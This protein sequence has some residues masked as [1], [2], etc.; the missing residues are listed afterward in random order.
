M[1]VR[2]STL[3]TPRR[4]RRGHSRGLGSSLVTR[5]RGWRAALRPLRQ[6][7][8]GRAPGGRTLATHRV[9]LSMPR[10]LQARRAPVRRLAARQPARR[11]PGLLLH[12]RRCAALRL[13]GPLR[14]GRCGAAR[15]AARRLLG[16]LERAAL[17]RGQEAAARAAHALHRVRVPRLVQERLRAWAAESLALRTGRRARVRV[18]IRRPL[19]SAGGAGQRACAGR[20]ARGCAPRGGAPRRPR[21]LERAGGPGP[22]PP[23]LEQLVLGLG[24]GALLAA[25]HD[26]VEL[27]RDD[28]HRL[29]A[30]AVVAAAQRLLRARRRQPKRS[31]GPRHLRSRWP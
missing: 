29:L 10:R 2:R 27:L 8:R 19:V 5:R 7:G 17:G 28:I 12:G 31:C 24:L 30:V 9:T 23:D 18:D 6:L 20:R 25:A 15:R 11:A 3:H 4:L 26:R 13:I 16:L 14:G 1:P 22:H 21:P